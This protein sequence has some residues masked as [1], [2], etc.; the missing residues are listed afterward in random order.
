MVLWANLGP[1]LD[2]QTSSDRNK[3]LFLRA[4]KGVPYGELMRLMD[5]LR[6]AGYLKVALVGLEGPPSPAGAPAQPVAPP[7][8]SP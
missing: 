1:A 4:D 5:T 3:R 2:Q 6:A 7:S 8:S